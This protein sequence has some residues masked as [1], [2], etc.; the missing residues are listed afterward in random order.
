MCPTP[1]GFVYGYRQPLELV[2]EVDLCLASVPRRQIIAA[3]LS[4]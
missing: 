3:D 2:A 1:E 4:E